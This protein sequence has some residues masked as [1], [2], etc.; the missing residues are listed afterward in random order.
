MSVKIGVLGCG[1]FAQSFITLWER[2]P[3]VEEL[4]I[5]D[6][7]PERARAYAERF[8]G[9]RVVD[10]FEQLLASDCDA[11]AIFTQ[12]WTHGALASR[13]LRAGK[14]VYSAVPMAITVP[15]IEDIFAAIAETGCLYMMGETSYYYPAVVFARQKLAEGAFGTIFYAEGDYLHDMDLGFYDA[16][17]YSGG[18]DWAATASFPPMLYPTHSIGGILGVLPSHAVSVSAL[19]VRDK[20][21]DGVF[22]RAISMFDNDVSNASALFETADGG[23]FRTNEF[24]RVGYPS[25]IQ[26]SRYRFF[27]TEGSFEQIATSSVWQDKSS[28]ED[29]SDLLRTKAGAEDDE[30]LSHVSPALREAFSSG[31]AR[32]HDRSLLPAEFTGAPNG[33]NGS[34]QYLA[35]NFVTALLTGRQPELNAWKSAR[36]TLPGILAHASV[37]DGGRRIA[38]PDFGDA[39][40]SEL[41]DGADSRKGNA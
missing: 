12:R 32:I 29:V 3:D 37:R 41:V 11:I 28:V 40:A 19:G 18:D 6:L 35:H 25:H 39:P 21:D 14:A 9:V 38:I 30:A 27:G 20:R 15:E 33:H 17:R 36:I 22:D 10:D 31:T 7:V 23:A 13:A 16:Y 24:R 26:E 4:Y 2:H 1:Q 34:H 5:T 8:P